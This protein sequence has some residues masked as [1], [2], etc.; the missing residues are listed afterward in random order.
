M[1]KNTFSQKV[2]PLALKTGATK[3][4]VS[5][6]DVFNASVIATSGQEGGL[7]TLLHSE[8]KAS[9]PTPARQVSPVGGEKGSFR[10]SWEPDIGQEEWNENSTADKTLEYAESSTATSVFLKE[11][12]RVPLL[13]REG[14]IQLAKQIEEARIEIDRT[15]WLLP[16]ARQYFADLQA[17]VHR[18][19]CRVQDLV[20]ASPLAEEGFGEIEDQS[21]GTEG[22]LEQT[23]Q[24][25]EELNRLYRQYEH[26]RQ[27]SARI[28][29]AHNRRR[30][31]KRAAEVGE[32]IIAQIHGL[33]FK[34]AVL[35]Q[36]LSR[37]KTMGREVAAL[38]GRLSEYHQ[39]LGLSAE[40]GAR[41][42]KRLARDERALTALAQRTGY[43][44]DEILA[45][46]E[47]Y[48]AT[49]QQIQEQER[50]RL[51]MPAAEFVQAVQRVEQA[52]E[53]LNRGKADLVAANL[54]LVVSIAKHYM[55]KGLQFSDLIQEGNIGLMKAVDKFEYRRGYKFS[56]Y[57]TWW[58]RQRI[59][60][61]LADQSRTIRVPVHMVEEAQKL[62]RVIRQLVQQLG[63]EPT[64]MEVAE[65]M[66][67][68]V[69]KVNEIFDCLKESVQLDAPVQEG[70]ETC[71]GDFIEDTNIPS[72]VSHA[73]REEVQQQV[74][75][76]LSTLSAR[77]AQV[78]RK[79]FGIGEGTDHT[80]EA[81]SKDFGVTR[82]RIRQIEAAALKKLR[83]PHYRKLLQDL[84]EK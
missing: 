19:E 3:A 18:G 64:R 10:R 80:L 42:I 32:K 53:R 29:S 79:R 58:I 73:E 34:P 50:Q 51:F 69:E 47:R 84:V 78:L 28:K 46:R 20:A 71:V 75:A 54:R 55:G 15:L 8:A 7:T 5:A 67:L 60:R 12:G 65:K 72:P 56:T 14:E 6:S 48:L 76:V 38:L 9:E 35:E 49:L 68:R 11:M 81:I 62:T 22:L 25:L 41:V 13:T 36:L 21:E 43:T 17:Q 23:V 44:T 82:E 4:T 77:E 37:V 70:S 40:A 66:G 59:N 57:A 61:A 45:V 1:K 16:L 30:M 39:K 52:E 63:R 33:Q 2:P 26:L 24:R 31:E 27:S 74:E 83:S